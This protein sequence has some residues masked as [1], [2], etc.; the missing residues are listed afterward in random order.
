MNRPSVAPYSKDYTSDEMMI[1]AACLR[2]PG[3]VCFIPPPDPEELRMLRDLQARILMA[4][5]A[6]A[7]PLKRE[8]S[9]ASTPSDIH[10]R[11]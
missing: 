11:A 5:R 4:H 1:V 2:W 6:I 8:S 9:P 10:E 7:L 3:C